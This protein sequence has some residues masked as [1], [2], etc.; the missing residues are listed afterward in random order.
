MSLHMRQEPQGT[1]SYFDNNH[2]SID[3]AIDILNDYL[4]PAQLILV[5]HENKLTLTSTSDRV[6]DELIP[7]YRHDD[8]SLIGR[9]ALATVVM[10]ITRMDPQT[11]VDER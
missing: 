9:N 3:D 11:A 2:Y 10:P 7:Y 6:P 1:L 5:R 4:L 8:L